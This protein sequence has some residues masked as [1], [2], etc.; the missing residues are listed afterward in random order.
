MPM[1]EN[2]TSLR[3]TSDNA[4]NHQITLIARKQMTV[5]GVKDVLAFDP[6]SVELMTDLGELVIDGEGMKM[7]TLDTKDGIVE[8]EGNVI[9]ITYLSHDGEK[10]GRKNPLK[11]LLG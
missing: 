2:N 5:S 9:A 3:R 6:S 4:P 8:L 7:G 11:R 1:P 10:Q